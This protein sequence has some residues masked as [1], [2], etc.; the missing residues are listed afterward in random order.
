MAN[1]GEFISVPFQFLHFKMWKKSLALHLTRVRMRVYFVYFINYSPALRLDDSHFCS[2][3]NENYLPFFG[4]VHYKTKN[5]TGEIN[6]ASVHEICY[7]YKARW[8]CAAVVAAVEQRTSP[9]YINWR[10]FCCNSKQKRIERNRI[11]KRSVTSNHMHIL[12]SIRCY[13]QSA[14]FRMNGVGCRTSHTKCMRAFV[15]CKLNDGE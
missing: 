10:C 7:A 14:Q 1:N 6:P 12:F 3:R 5:Q 8:I 13:T 15:R 9:S 4:I 2:V 11:T